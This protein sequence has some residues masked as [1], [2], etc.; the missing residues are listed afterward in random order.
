M[1][2]GIIGYGKMGE[3]IE[4]ISIQKGYS[5][6]FKIN[7]KNTHELTSNALSKVDV[8]FEFSNPN[9]AFNNVLLCLQ[10]K[11]PIVCGTTGWMKN[12]LEAKK[13]CLTKK[14]A[15]LYAANF[16]IGLNIFLQLNK[17]FT[18]LIEKTNYKVEIIEKHHKTKKDSPS[19]TAIMIANQISKQR[20]D[21]L[22][23]PITSKRIGKLKGEH[24]INCYSKT[25]A[26]KL[27]HKANSRTGFAKGA[28][29]AAEFIKD[30]KGFFSMEDVI[31][32]L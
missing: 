31:N 29:L 10:N 2:L 12:L 27:S 25:D 3:E 13:V 21:C 16:S 8:V 15:L 20:H 24:I 4:K 1:N 23:P 6:K 17:E 30:K 11:K 5:I 7:S 26:I 18:K 32:N 14:G 22:N 19:G 28:I 9:T